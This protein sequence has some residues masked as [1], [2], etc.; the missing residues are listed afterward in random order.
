MADQHDDIYIEGRWRPT[1][2]ARRIP[3]VNPAS[4]EQWA[5]VPDGDREDIQDAVTAAR[6]ALPSWASTSPKGR[7]ALI[8]RLADELE[9]RSDALSE[10][11]TTE[12][13][14]PIAESSSAPG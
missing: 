13:G 3:V 6:R 12:N 11:I 4:G 9:A 5:S 14:T 7:A 10:I 2:S 1:H 8:L